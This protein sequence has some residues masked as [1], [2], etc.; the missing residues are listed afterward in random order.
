MKLARLFKSYR[1]NALTP[2]ARLGSGATKVCMRMPHTSMH[3][4][5]T[6][7]HILPSKPESSCYQWYNL[8]WARKDSLEYFTR[9]TCQESQQHGS[10]KQQTSGL[11]KMNASASLAKAHADM[12][13]RMPKAVR[14]PCKR[15]RN[16][17]SLCTPYDPK[18][19]GRC[20]NGT[21]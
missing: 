19:F 15:K 6:T 13:I 8:Q 20:T 21:P 4:T 1:T 5:S 17:N 18:Y 16:D 14:H 7:K 12:T 2:E 9:A 3:D 10:K 11:R